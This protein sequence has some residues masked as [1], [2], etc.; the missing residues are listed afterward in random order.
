[1][2]DDRNSRDSVADFLRKLGY[3]VDEHENG[4]K[5]LRSF[6]IHNYQMVL[7]DIRMPNMNGI[8]L[9]KAISA[10]PYGNNV[11]VVLF[12]GYGELET[13]IQALCLGAFDYLLKPLDV[14][15]LAKVTEKIAERRKKL[16]DKINIILLH[17]NSIFAEGLKY[18]FTRTSNLN[19][20]GEGESFRGVIPSLKSQRVDILLVDLDHSDY[21]QEDIVSLKA[22]FPKLNIVFLYSNQEL[23]TENIK[24]CASVFIS[25]EREGRE[26]IYL[27]EKLAKGED[28]SNYFPTDMLSQTVEILEQLTCR[29]YEVLRLLGE[30]LTNKEIAES[31]YVS[32]STVR[33]YVSNIL[34]KLNVTNRAA[35]AAF[36]VKYLK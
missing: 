35:A 19:F 18:V 3:Q 34:Q 4:Y 31:L 17:K 8:E 25:K 27:L 13:A 10:S 20:I 14:K 16:H 2:D 36:A 12:T 9:L 28:I 26:I 1:M 29:E 5:A 7:T 11:D 22:K 21:Q 33:T 24:K 32:H 23:I 6:F 30:G 15:E